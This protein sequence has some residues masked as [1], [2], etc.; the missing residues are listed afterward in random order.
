MAGQQAGDRKQ[1]S[2]FLP[3]GRPASGCKAHNASLI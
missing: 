1:V 3:H 2:G